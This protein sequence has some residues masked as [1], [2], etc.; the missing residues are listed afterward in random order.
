MKKNH[1]DRITPSEHLNDYLK[2]TY[3]ERLNWLEEAN[4]LVSAV[5]GKKTKRSRPQAPAHSRVHRHPHR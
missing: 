5:P 1:E 2:S 3:Q 4:K